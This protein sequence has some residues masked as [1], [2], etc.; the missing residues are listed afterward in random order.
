MPKIVRTDRVDGPGS[1]VLE[2]AGG[3]E[4]GPLPGETDDRPTEG[5]EEEGLADS[6]HPSHC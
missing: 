5:G 2:L 4:R 3:G 6:R 1:Q